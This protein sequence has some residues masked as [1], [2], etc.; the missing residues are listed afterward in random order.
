MPN[1]HE[2][3]QIEGSRQDIWPYLV[4]PDKLLAWQSG[5]VELVAEWEGDPKP[6]DRANGAIRIAGR[7]V[8]FQTEYTE[9]HPPDR[10]EFKSAQS[11]FP[12]VVWVTLQDSD[13]GTRVTYHGEAESF[14]GFFG[15]LADPIVE[16]LYGRDVRGNLQNLKVLVEEAEATP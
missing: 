8:H 15:K 9:V 16:K 14:R 7:Q 6:G 13:G 1:V 12:F 3:I 4:E 10:V 11:P 5:V 2:S